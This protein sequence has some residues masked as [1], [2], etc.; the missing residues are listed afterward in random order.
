M[1][2]YLVLAVV[3]VMVALLSGCASET[4]K[5]GITTTTP[6]VTGEAIQT[7]TP[8]PEEA[9]KT[10]E[11]DEKELLKK[12]THAEVWE[13]GRNWD[14]DAENDGLV[15]YIRLLDDK[16]E[17][18]KFYDVNIPI[19]IYIYTIDN[20]RARDRLIYKGTTNITNWEEI[21]MYGRGIRIPF[22]DMNFTD[23]EKAKEGLGYEIFIKTYLPDGRVV[24]TKRYGNTTWW[25]QP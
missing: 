3:V 1:R 7:P 15:V 14:E 24:E 21:R 10:T 17:I 8:A 13:Y 23:I 2:K 16:D 12:V 4:E 19:E 18:V 20:E 11:F 5:S 22:E 25:W 6:T 9:A